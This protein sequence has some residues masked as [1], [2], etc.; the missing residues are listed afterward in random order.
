MS[1]L[2]LLRALRAVLAS[3]ALAAV[4][5]VY[6]TSVPP[7]GHGELDSPAVWVAPDASRSLLFVTDKT[8]DYVEVHDPVRNVYVGRFGGSGSE[9]GRFQRPNSVA[10]AYA[11]PSTTGPQD[12]LFVVERDNQRVSAF[13]LPWGLYLGAFGGGSLQEPMGIGLHWEAGQLRA[14]ITDT[15]SAPDR[16]FVFGIAITATGLT[17]TP[18]FSFAVPSNAVLESILI[19]PVQQRALVCDEGTRDVMVFDLAGQLVERFGAGVFVDDPEG[20]ALWDAGDGDGY[21]IVSD[22][23]AQPVQFEVFGRRGYTWLGHFTGATNGTDG[24]ALVQQ[25]LPNLPAGSFFAAHEDR[26]VH[27]Y[28]WSDIAA[29]MHL[30]SQSPCAPVDASTAPAPGRRLAVAPNPSNPA[31]TIEWR[32]DAPARVRLAVHDLRGRCL[33]ELLDAEQPAGR[34]ALV[35]DGRSRSGLALPSGVYLLRLQ[36]GE[37][38]DATK[39]TLVQ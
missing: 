7:G 3:S 22:Q 19:D 6:E 30:C 23:V 27:A 9:P 26:A 35:W 34:H 20:I 8:L 1:L 38:T 16:I 39:I 24:V 15:G 28:S 18:L 2:S 33:A 5:L 14:W 12:V 32:L 25:P 29:A 37:R 17:G 4:P 10:V 11:V 36:A 21:V 31:A 13:V